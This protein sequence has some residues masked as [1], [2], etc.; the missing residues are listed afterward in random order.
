[1]R[2]SR[3]SLLRTGGGAAVLGLMAL[4]GAAPALAAPAI[5]GRKRLA[6]R[7]LSFDCCNTG[8]TLNRVT[9]WAD[10][11]YFPDALARINYALRDYRS[12]EVYPIDPKVLDLLH[13][14]GRRL[15]SD[16]R[17]ELFSGYRSPETNA[18]LQRNEPE[19][20]THSLHMTGQA[21]DIFLPGRSLQAIRDT[22][23]AMGMGGVGYYPD[24]D[25]LHVDVGRV[26]R[27]VGL[28]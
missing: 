3:R 8:E 10:G 28:G 27:W 20:A 12:G 24:A 15:D 17:Y 23:L 25:F 7:T 26:R 1:M 22:A 16:C 18:M 19:V 21:A 2:V 13:Q 11:R 14:M 4:R 6:A 5:I 9:Y